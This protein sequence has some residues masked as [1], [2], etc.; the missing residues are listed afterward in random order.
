MK[1]RYSR[2][3]SKISEYGAIILVS[4]VLIGSGAAY[5]I[6]SDGVTAL[7]NTA[8]AVTGPD[9]VCKSIT[10]ASPTGLTEYVPT[11]SVAEWQSFVA[12]PPTGVAV[13]ACVTDLIVPN[14]TRA[15]RH[16]VADIAT[17]AR[18][19]I[20]AGYQQGIYS[21]VGFSGWPGGSADVYQNGSWHTENDIIPYAAEIYCFNVSSYA[22]FTNQ[23]YAGVPIISD[24]PTENK[25]CQELGYQMGG[26]IDQTIYAPKAMLYTRGT[27]RQGS[28]LSAPVPTTLRCFN[29]PVGT[30]I[31]DPLKLGYKL[32]LSARQF[33]T[34][35]PFFLSNS[36]H[37]YCRELGHDSGVELD[38][39]MNNGGY[40]NIADY[41]MTT[42]GAWYYANSGSQPGVYAK[43]IRCFS[44]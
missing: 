11:A 22:D 29:M 37:Q 26:A 14:P 42:S 28:F 25:R 19:C 4:V 38:I 2:V 33:W 27:W 17:V 32:G 23:T 10:N 39:E 6:A 44:N 1:S 16:I 3:R 34:D 9:A 21:S 40:V 15:G 8:I 20:E 31:T 36:T 24:S 18:Y 41:A 43:S 35:F 13:N 7:F 12:H 30:N 5:A